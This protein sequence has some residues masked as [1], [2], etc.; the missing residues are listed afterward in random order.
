MKLLLDTNAYSE[1]KRGHEEVAYLVRRAEKIYL[2]AIVVGELLYGF[3][4][5]RQNARNRNELDRFLDNPYVQF[6]PVSHTTAD[7]FARIATSLRRKGTP[8]PANDIWIAAGAMET[9]AELVSFDAHFEHVDG[10]V[11]VTPAE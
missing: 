2:P 7:R 6:L 8:L 5:G 11:W 9:G 3:S 10:L 4:C 1:L